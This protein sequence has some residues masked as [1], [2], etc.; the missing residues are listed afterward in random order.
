MKKIFLLVLFISFLY[1]CKNKEYTLSD[2]EE[3]NGLSY[4]R[5]HKE[6]YTGEAIERLGQQI[7][8]I[9]V[10]EKGDQVLGTTFYPNGNKEYE[11]QFRSGKENGYWRQYFYNGQLNYE[12]HKT[13]GVKNGR[14]TSYYENGQ[15]EF[16][17]TYKDEK[18]IGAFVSY[19]DDGKLRSKSDSLGTDFHYYRDGKILMK[20]EKDKTQI[21]YNKRGEEVSYK[22]IQSELE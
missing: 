1:G 3:K 20:K 11:I 14:T 9:N 10:F 12:T 2:L 17:G 4:I 6:S 22:E 5:G 16:E 7:V 13:E 15:L 19:Y 8:T 21:Y 18:A